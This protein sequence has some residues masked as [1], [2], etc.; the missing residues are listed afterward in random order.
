[1]DPIELFWLFLK[2]AL[3]STSGTGN[4]PM[5]HTDVIGRGWA[6]EQMFAE[7]LAIGQLS[8]GPTGLW[9]LSIAYL[10]D[11]VR[12]AVLALVAITI[13]PLSVIGIN[14]LYVRYGEYLAVQ[15]FMRGLMLAVASMFGG[16]I[17]QIFV[18][19]GVD[20]IAIYIAGAAFF[21]T[22]RKTIPVPL[23]LLAAGVVGV[24]MSKWPILLTT[25][26]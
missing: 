15:G 20:S 24:I 10:I 19:N 6:T 1:M 16:V 26:Y 5:L 13:P 4:L 18:Q 14:A 22:W 3:F 11:G 23:I 12:G 7:A 2:A 9:V 21:L 25:N 8:P 17:L